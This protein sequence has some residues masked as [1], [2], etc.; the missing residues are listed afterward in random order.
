L[1][2]RAESDTTPPSASDA[3]SVERGHLGRTEGAT[4][5]RDPGPA[6]TPMLR[7]TPRRELWSGFDHSSVMVMELLA[8]I[9]TWTAIGWFADRQLGTGP[10]LLVVGALIGNAAGLYLV[11]L[12]GARMDEQER[13]A[14]QARREARTRER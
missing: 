3:A 11:F 2:L 9:L 8:G 5:T 14:Q 4:P 13:A 12:R 10:W 7:G 1:S 6:V